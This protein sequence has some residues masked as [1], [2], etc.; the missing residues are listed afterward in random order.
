MAR[1]EWR[2]RRPLA[3]RTAGRRLHGHDEGRLFSTTGAW[4][5]STPWSRP[6][7]C[8]SWSSGASLFVARP[9]VGSSESLRRQPGSARPRRDRT[10]LEMIRA[11]L[12]DRACNV[13]STSTLSA[14]SHRLS[15][16]GRM[17]GALAYWRESGR[18]VVVRQGGG[19]RNRRDRQGLRSPRTPGSTP[20]DGPALPTMRRRLIDWSSSS[21]PTGHG[22]PPGVRPPGDRGVR[23]ESGIL[24]NAKGERFMWEIPPEAPATS[25]PR[26]RGGGRGSMPPLRTSATDA[27]RPPSSRRAQ[28]GARDLSPRCARARLSARRRVP[29]HQLL[30]RPS[31][32]SGSS[33]PCTTVPG[34]GGRGHHEAA[35]GSG[36]TT[37]YMMGGVRV[38]PDTAAATVPGLFAAGERRAGLHAPTAGRGTRSPT[39]W[40]SAAA[41]PRRREHAKGLAGQPPHL[42]GRGRR[43]ARELVAPSSA[44][45]ARALRGAI[46][47]CRR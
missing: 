9:T 7:A 28:R 21:P 1:A 43:R 13:A 47:R 33:P 22:G 8:A 23:G 36:P 18:F 2:R 42:R 3:R 44:R 38:D 32:C 27:R 6:I 35:D 26:P 16:G 19:A 37:H 41:R 15:C 25:T 45:A 14:R 29:R 10:G 40:C 30:C 11:T 31:A 4:R 39:C 24:R 17:A 34:A 12:Q 5:S 20:G 46:T